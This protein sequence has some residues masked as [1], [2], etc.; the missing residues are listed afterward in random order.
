[1]HL[2]G[3]HFSAKLPEALLFVLD[4]LDCNHTVTFHAGM[5][6]MIARCYS[7]IDFMSTNL[8]LM[9]DR[10]VISIS[11]GYSSVDYNF[12]YEIPDFTGQSPQ[13]SLAA[14]RGRRPHRTSLGGADRI[15]AGS[16][17]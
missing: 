13:D 3:A 12:A 2:G 7:C 6:Y 4:R 11:F 17:L 15:Q 8:F 16:Y 1:Q 14:H 10:D 9:V 5:S